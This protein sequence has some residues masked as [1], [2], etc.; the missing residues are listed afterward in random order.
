MEYQ[1]NKISLNRIKQYTQIDK[2]KFKLVLDNPDQELEV[3]EFPY[4][5][6][7]GLVKEARNIGGGLYSFQVDVGNKNIEIISGILNYHRIDDFLNTRQM[8]LVNMGRYRNFR[9]KVSQGTFVFANEKNQLPL[10]FEQIPLANGDSNRVGLG[11]YTAYL[12]KK[13]RG[14]GKYI[15]KFYVGLDGYFYYEDCALE[16][17]GHKFKVIQ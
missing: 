17:N 10:L 5:I 12:T 3:V 6:Y 2:N 8:V 7:Y 14:T 4:E 1:G 11:Q 13:L 15:E 16:V 9:G